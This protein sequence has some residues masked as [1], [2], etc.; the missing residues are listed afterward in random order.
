MNHIIIF[1]R[2]E[3][4]KFFKDL[5][6]TLSL[7]GSVGIVSP[8]IDESLKMLFILNLSLVFSPLV[9]GSFRL[10]GIELSEVTLVV[11]GSKSRLS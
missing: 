5:D 4:G 1:W 7:S 9:L 6:F 2:F 10:G 3:F 11:Y 8:S